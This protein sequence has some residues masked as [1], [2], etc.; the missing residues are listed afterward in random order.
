MFNKI[1]NELIYL[2]TL[3]RILSSLRHINNDEKAIITK[4]AGFA[5]TNPQSIAIY[6]E[7]R[8]VSYKELMEGANRYSH[9][10]LKNN[11][12]KEMSLLY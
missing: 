8:E 6:Y 4:I 3:R 7:D 5:E 12:K 9:W 2:S 11:L 1:K 10:F